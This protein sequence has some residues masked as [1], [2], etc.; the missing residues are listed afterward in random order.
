MDV[1]RIGFHFTPSDE[2]LFQIL[3]MKLRGEYEGG[4]VTE[5]DPYEKEPWLVFDK[6]EPTT[7]YVF[8]SL[9]KKSRSRM[10]RKVGC[11][12]WKMERSV[13]VVDWEENVIGFKKM[14]TFEEKK[15]N[16][17]NGRWIMHEYSLRD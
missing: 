2:E 9:K 7:F 16:T 14:L 5:V 17:E 12:T 4:G 1:A 15:K 6:N 8:T 10:E 11:G 3:G 13:E